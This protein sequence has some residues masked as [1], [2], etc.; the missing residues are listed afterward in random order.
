[1]WY[2]SHQWSQWYPNNSHLMSR[3]CCIVHSK[4][5]AMA[6]KIFREEAC[7]VYLSLNDLLH[8]QKRQLAAMMF[9]NP[10][11]KVQMMKKMDLLVILMTNPQ[12]LKQNL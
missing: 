12:M 11:N 1:M 8:F 6:R 5:D 10:H 2:S 3:S 7:R 9:V 4:V